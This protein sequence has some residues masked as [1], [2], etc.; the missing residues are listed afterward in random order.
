MTTTDT[1]T[2]DPWEGLSPAGRRLASYAMLGR[3]FEEAEM[4]SWT[5]PDCGIVYRGVATTNLCVRCARQPQNMAE[6]LRRIL[7]GCQQ[8]EDALN[9][10]DTAFARAYL[11]G[12]HD[13]AT[14]LLD[15]IVSES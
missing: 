3:M 8:T 4:E 2:R 6:T 9:R 10:Q 7:K 5:C 13:N 12:I 15:A 1:G 14:E 11:E